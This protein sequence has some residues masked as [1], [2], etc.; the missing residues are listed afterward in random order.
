MIIDIND[1]Y[2][3]R[4]NFKALEVAYEHIEKSWRFWLSRRSH[5]GGINWS[6]FNKIRRIFPLLKPR[7]VHNI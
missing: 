6:M 3:V 1:F 7:I 5:R 2:G 4:G